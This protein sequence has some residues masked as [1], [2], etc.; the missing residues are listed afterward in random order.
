[1]Q[2]AL[3]QQDWELFLADFATKNFNGMRALDLAKQKKP[4]IPCIML[5][6]RLEEEA[7][8]QAVKA[9]ADNFLE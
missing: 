9:G 2:A 4:A 1:M 7:V 5:A 8:A 6:N 3:P